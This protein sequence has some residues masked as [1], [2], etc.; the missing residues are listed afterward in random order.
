MK[1]LSY[2]P[3]SNSRKPTWEQTIPALI[4][5]CG[6]GHWQGKE[7]WCLV[8]AVQSWGGSLLLSCVM[9]AGQLGTGAQLGACS[10]QPEPPLECGPA[11]LHHRTRGGHRAVAGVSRGQAVTLPSAEHEELRWS[12]TRRWGAGGL[13]VG[14]SFY[15]SRIRFLAFWQI[16]LLF[17]D[18]T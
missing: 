14:R 6:W 7:M 9:T 1:L 13:A 12:R 15:Y 10:Y 8:G 18:R 3:K 16:A 4:S 11:G 2:A 5:P 17:A